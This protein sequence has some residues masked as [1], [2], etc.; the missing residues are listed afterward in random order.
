MAS[1]EEPTKGCYITREQCDAIHDAGGNECDL[2]V[3]FTWYGTDKDG[4]PLTS[5]NQR[6]SMFNPRHIKDS[7]K[8]RLPNVNLPNW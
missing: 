4:K 6:F 8:D 1:I 3:Y 5:A 2:T 7:F